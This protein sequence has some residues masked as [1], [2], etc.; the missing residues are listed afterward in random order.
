MI[1]NKNKWLYYW[2]SGGTAEIDFLIE[3]DHEIYPL[4][5]KSG[6]SQK[7]KSL[8]AYQEKYAPSN[9]YRTSLM[10]LKHDGAL[11]NYP[12]YLISALTRSHITKSIDG[13]SPKG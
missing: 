10:N 7:K 6:T 1:A 11:Y 2:K 8:I 12:L 13:I 5:V 3:G 4:E 9:L